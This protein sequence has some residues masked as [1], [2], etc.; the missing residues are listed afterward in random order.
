MKTS[1]ALNSVKVLDVFQAENNTHNTK[2]TKGQLGNTFLTLDN[3]FFSAC[4]FSSP[5]EL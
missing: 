5:E 2:Q 3:I 1:A 4:S